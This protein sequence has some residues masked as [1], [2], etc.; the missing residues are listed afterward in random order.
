M[1]VQPVG[2]FLSCSV[3]RQ[4]FPGVPNIAGVAADMILR[5]P[6]MRSMYALMGIRRAGRTSILNMFGDKINVRYRCTVRVGQGAVYCSVAGLPHDFENQRHHS[7]SCCF[8]VYLASIRRDCTHVGTYGAER[9]HRRGLLERD[10]DLNRR[11]HVFFKE[12]RK[13]L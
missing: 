12:E 3:V 9:W 11:F 6:G 4:A 10:L 5:M 13:M 7:W 8:R 2:Q 1:L